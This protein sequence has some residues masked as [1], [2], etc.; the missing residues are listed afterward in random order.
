METMTIPDL[1]LRLVTNAIDEF[2]KGNIPAVL[3]ACAEDVEWASFE[4]EAV[5]FARTYRGKKGVGEFFAT[6]AS[7]VEYHAFD[8]R[9]ALQS[10][11]K[12]YVKTFQEGVVKTTGMS[13]AHHFIM[14]FRVSDEK[15]RS[16]YSYVDSHGLA[17]AFSVQEANKATVRRFNKKFIE[18]GDINVFNEIMAPDF[19][20]H[21]APAGL[22][23][24]PGGVLLL[25]ND[26]LKPALHGLRVEIIRQVAENDLV[27]THKLFHA[28]HRGEL[29]GVPA[30]GKPVTIE[31]MDIIR[32]RDGR[33]AEH[34]N[35]IDWQQVINQLSSSN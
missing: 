13:F 19:V 21:S 28:S 5:P 11:E 33:F 30:T 6:L 7:S 31:V 18:E 9:E 16:F 12:V 1:N 23:Q 2:K 35:I 34:H 32:L 29:M 3:E 25:F 17:M 20:N 14:E 10:G 8:V 15:I 27:T 22:P 26:I 4:N 24:G